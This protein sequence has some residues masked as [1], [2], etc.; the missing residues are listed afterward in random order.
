M[1]YLFRFEVEFIIFVG[2][3]VILVEIFIWNDFGLWG[4]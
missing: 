2:Y 3:G 4:C 1:L